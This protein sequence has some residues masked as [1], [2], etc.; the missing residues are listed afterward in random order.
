MNA[1]WYADPES[2][3][4]QRYWDGRQWTAHVQANPSGYA[5]PAVRP[6][7]G[8]PALPSPAGP[9]YGPMVTRPAYPVAAKSPGLSLL[10][11]F[12]LPGVGSMVNGDVGIG[13]AI[14]S[15][16]LISCVLVLLFIGIFGV[17]GFWIWGM[18]DA[19]AGAQRW[20]RRHGIVS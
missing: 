4:Q 6:V 12:F 5:V 9:G 13:L 7:A 20:N 3:G 11:S 17:F 8:P 16:Y 19:Y 15:G 18:V 1:G 14:L 2:S 10:I